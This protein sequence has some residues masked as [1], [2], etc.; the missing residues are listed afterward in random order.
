MKRALPLLL[1][2][3]ACSLRAPRTSQVAPCSSTSQCDR[4]DVCFLGECR[5]PASNLSVVRVE[6]RPPDNSPFGVMQASNIDLHVSVLNDFALQPPLAASGSVSQAPDAPTGAVTPVPGATITFTEHAPAIPDRVEQIAA[7]TDSSGAFTARL[8]QGIW[9]VLVQPPLQLPPFRP[10]ALDTAAPAL[11]LVL[12]KVSSLVRVS[13]AVDSSDGGVLA[14]ASVTAVDV[15]GDPLSAPALTQEDGGYSL[16]LPPGSTSYLLQVGPPPNVDAGMAAEAFDPLPVYDELTPTAAGVT[17]A[18]PPEVVMSGQVLDS[19]NAPVAAA[20]V[21][22][23]SDGM[24]WN[25]ARSTTAGGDG[26]YTL[27]LR[28]GTYVVEAAPSSAASAPGVSGELPVTLSADTT[29]NFTCPPKVRHFGL[30]I[31][32]DGHTTAANYQVTAT[33]LADKLLTTRTG[34]TT[35]TGLD[36]IYHVIADPGQYRFEVVPPPEAGLPRKIVQFDLSAIEPGE[37]ALPTIEIS[38]PLSVVGTVCGKPGGGKCGTQDAPVPGATVSFFSVD[39]SGAHGIFLGSA[40]TDA[41]GHYKA[42]V[43]DV[44]QPGP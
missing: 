17:I 3:A 27:S 15:Q 44:A 41:S 24:P 26:S 14:G 9:D 8:P 29:Q 37:T 39:A 1:L 38:P 31:T 20:R 7:Q 40:L 2:A 22:A 42:V 32:P 10:A 16:L 35:A 12:P 6:V 19:S 30:V 25:L 11:Q 18:L 36:G 33:R 43:P 23:R 28:A 34:F 21:Y 13:G 5:P 4:T